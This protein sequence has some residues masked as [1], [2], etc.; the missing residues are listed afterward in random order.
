MSTGTQQQPTQQ[1][2]QPQQTIPSYAQA[3]AAVP[4]TKRVN[5]RMIVFGLILIGLL[6]LPLYIY[7]DSVLTGGIKV[8]SDRVEV[9]LKAMSNFPFDQENG[10]VNDIPQQWR[11]LDGKRIEVSGEIW[12]PDSASADVDHFD[13]VY[14]IAKCCFSGP[15][16]IQHFVKSRVKDNGTVPYYNG[17][18]RVVGVLKVNVK[19]DPQTNKIGQVYE[20]EVESVTQG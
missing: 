5:P 13:L 20:M 14:S 7:L 6:G 9:D 11:D 1:Q 12:A 4:I 2:Q 3:P 8:H 15:P 19:K 10:T 18:V 16:Q 17:L